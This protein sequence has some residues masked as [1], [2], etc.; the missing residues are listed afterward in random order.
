MSRRSNVYAGGQKCP[1]SG[2]ADRTNL[3][4]SQAWF[5]GDMNT[6]PL[7]SSADLAA[8]AFKALGLREKLPANLKKRISG[9]RPMPTEAVAGSRSKDPHAVRNRLVGTLLYSLLPPPALQVLMDLPDESA[10]WSRWTGLA[11]LTAERGRE[12]DNLTD[13]LLYAGYEHPMVTGLGRVLDAM[14]NDGKPKGDWPLDAIKAIHDFHRDTMQN[15]AARAGDPDFLIRLRALLVRL[16]VR[17][18]ALREAA[19][20][21]VW[22]LPQQD[23]G[24]SW[25]LLPPMAWLKKLLNTTLPSIPKTT[26]SRWREV[27]KDDMRLHWGSVENL[28]TELVA[29]T[30]ADDQGTALLRLRVCGHLVLRR[31]GLALQRVYGNAHQQVTT[32]YTAQVRQ[33]IKT[34]RETPDGVSL[35]TQGNP[36]RDLRDLALFGPLPSTTGGHMAEHVFR[37]PEDRLEALFMCCPVPGVLFAVLFAAANMSSSVP[38]RDVLASSGRSVRHPL[39][40]SPLLH[41][42]V[43]GALIDSLGDAS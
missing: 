1:R 8:E 21:V 40:I 17:E 16:V 18:I 38:L 39:G 14:D 7:P 4:R 30:G 26:R 13:S 22:D 34:M 25:H 31:L 35:G 15:V 28:V 43:S 37:K 3:V 5:A 9:T 42:S 23:V 19:A 41:P 10:A 27:V 36:R 6:R 24:P 11:H 29:I 33:F 12:W 2:T 20:T 32:A